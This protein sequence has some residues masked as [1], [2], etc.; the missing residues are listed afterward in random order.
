[1]IRSHVL[2]NH[3]AEVNAVLPESCSRVQDG[4]GQEHSGSEQVSTP[5]CN[6][7]RGITLPRT[8]PAAMFFVEKNFL[9]LET[10][11]AGALS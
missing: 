5:E 4:T 7:Q 6:K 10:R 2:M 8:E 3:L 9:L 1:M 11:F